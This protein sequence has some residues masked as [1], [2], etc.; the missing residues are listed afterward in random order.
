MQIEAREIKDNLKESS[1]LIYV[2]YWDLSIQDRW[3][4]HIQVEKTDRLKPTV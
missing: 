2:I 1:K 4:M 3:V